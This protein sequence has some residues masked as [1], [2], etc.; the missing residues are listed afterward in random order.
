M[1]SLGEGLLDPFASKCIFF[2]KKK[3]QTLRVLVY[4]HP[5]GLPLR[6]KGHFF[7]LPI[8]KQLLGVGSH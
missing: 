6:K 3:K 2:K 4:R 1:R 8:P 5:G 7:G